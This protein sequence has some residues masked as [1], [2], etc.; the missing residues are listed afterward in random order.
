MH[1]LNLGLN[2]PRK[3]PCLTP[4]SMWE[5]KTEILYYKRC[6]HLNLNVVYRRNVESWNICDCHYL[7]TAS[8][9][10]RYVCMRDCSTLICDLH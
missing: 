10:I 3:C 5:E 6:S 7:V 1:K 8:S 2:E 9:N 4:T